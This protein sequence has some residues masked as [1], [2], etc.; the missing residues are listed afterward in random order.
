[1]FDMEER[2]GHN[3][4]MRLFSILFL[5]LLSVPNVLTAAVIYSGASEL[6]LV[7][8]GLTEPLAMEV[9][10]ASD[11]INVVHNSAT[12][13][14]HIFRLTAIA[15]GDGAD[16]PLIGL[17]FDAVLPSGFVVLNGSAQATINMGSATVVIT[18]PVSNRYRLA[19]TDPINDGDSIVVQLELY[20]ETAATLGSAS[21]NWEINAGG[22]LMGNLEQ[23]TVIESGEIVG[24]VNSS[25][26]AVA[27]GESIII[28]I[29]LS[30]PG[31]AGMFDIQFDPAANIVPS[32]FSLSFNSFVT[33]GLPAGFS[34]DGSNVLTIPYLAA[35]DSL[36]VSINASAYDCDD[37]T[38]LTKVNDIYTR[39]NALGDVELVIS[40]ALLPTSPELSFIDDPLAS[41]PVVVSAPA[42]NIV[43][44]AWAPFQIHVQNR[45][46]G[47]AQ[48]ISLDT[49][50]EL[51]GAS[52]EVRII[53]ANADGWIYTGADGVFSLPVLTELSGN[54]LPEN[55]GTSTL[56]FE[57][58]VVPTQQCNPVTDNVQWAFTYSD[59]CAGMF[60][61]PLYF[62]EFN[63]S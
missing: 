5:L 24:K 47:V 45:G 63:F 44:D 32:D 3:A 13:K 29:T 41:M 58:R 48:A 22:A 33:A 6:D 56:N 20:P 36:T 39:N 50:L 1:M 8:W 34:I 43:Y 38:F 61:F 11:G 62:S 55:G 16:F 27:I 18:N 40:F 14:A 9:G 26:S 53:G 28:D 31:L 60:S 23:T 46:E 30:N 35:G 37:L 21:L 2:N 19:I 49:S 54:A 7:D 25:I 17:E 4:G 51:L 52:I 15:S 42:I 59:S 10:G 12:P 57:A